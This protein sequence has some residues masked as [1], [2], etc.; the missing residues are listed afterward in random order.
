MYSENLSI[1]VISTVN[2]PAIIIQRLSH[3]LDP[4]S[5]PMVDHEQPIANLA[6]K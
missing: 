3:S 5:K 4:I 6:M 1:L 2:G